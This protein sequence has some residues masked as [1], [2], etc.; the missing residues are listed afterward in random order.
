[1]PR[2]SCRRAG[3]R[4]ASRTRSTPARSRSSP[5]SSPTPGRPRPP[6]TTWKRS[7]TRPTPR[8]SE[9][10]A[11]LAENDSTALGVVAALQ[12]KDYETVPVSGQDGDTGQP[13]ERRRGPPVRRRLEGRQRAR[14]GR[15]RGRAAAVRG[16][17][18][19]RRHRSRMGSSIDAVAPRPAL[20]ASPFTTPGRQDRPGD[21]NESPDT[22]KPQPDHARRTCD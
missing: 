20:T 22:L 8:A 16:H 19:R 18:D 21:N 15:R 14:Q 11:V 13:A 3:T 1:M 5:T 6:R 10:D 4:R 17:G 2:P 12:A 9:I 7:S